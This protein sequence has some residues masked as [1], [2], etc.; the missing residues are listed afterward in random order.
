MTLTRRQ[1]K[2]QA[3]AIEHARGPAP[4]PMLEPD[5]EGDWYP[6]LDPE[7]EKAPSCPGTGPRTRP[8][9]SDEVR[10]VATPGRPPRGDLGA[11]T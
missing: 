10:D 1:A 9:G 5:P 6:R 2:W 7:P 4:D 11:K 3:R 8:A